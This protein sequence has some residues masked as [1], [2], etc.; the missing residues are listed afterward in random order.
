MVPAAYGERGATPAM[1]LGPS[2]IASSPSVCTQTYL[3]FSVQ[4]EAE[5]KSLN[6][7]LRTKFFRFLVSLRKITQH[8]TRSTYTWVPSQMWDQEWT[9]ADLYSKYGL[10]K[11][12]IAYVESRVRPLEPIGSASQKTIAPI[13]NKASHA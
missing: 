6:S 1:V 9:D 11:A 7:Y 10:S 8:A 12:D 3:F 13:F 4:S 2:Y 5:A